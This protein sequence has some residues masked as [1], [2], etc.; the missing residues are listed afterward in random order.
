MYV[1]ACFAV[2]NPDDALLSRPSYSLA[3]PPHGMLFDVFAAVLH[4]FLSIN[5]SWE[6]PPPPSND[7]AELEQLL[8]P[9]LPP[10]AAVPEA[11]E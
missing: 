5:P 11:N 8:N 1:L 9:P 4:F 6:A 2:V 10:A 7:A 3:Q